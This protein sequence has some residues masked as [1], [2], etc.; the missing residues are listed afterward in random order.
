MSINM[1]IIGEGD[2]KSID[3]TR[4]MDDY[5]SYNL[6]GWL[7]DVR[8]YAQVPVLAQ[9][10]GLPEDALPETREYFEPGRGHWGLTWYTVEELLDFDWNQP[11]ENRR[12]TA[13]VAEN[14]W[15]GAATAEPGQG[16][17]TTYLEEFSYFRDR[18]L[19]W[20][21]Q[22]VHRIIMDFG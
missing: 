6:Y 13:Q 19:E 3:I 17:M 5:Q 4:D 12:Y 22:G 1:Y 14:V 15:N 20:K 21:A 18:L 7:A 10:R 16:R 8:N 9:P 11:F 2:G